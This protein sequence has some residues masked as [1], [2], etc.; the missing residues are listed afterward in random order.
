MLAALAAATRLKTLLLKDLNT[1]DFLQ[2]P[3]HRH[4]D[5]RR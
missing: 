1:Y 4:A 2:A 3:L 5:I